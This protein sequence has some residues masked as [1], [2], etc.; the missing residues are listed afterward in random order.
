MK[1]VS[2]YLTGLPQVQRLYTKFSISRFD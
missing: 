1:V 2:V